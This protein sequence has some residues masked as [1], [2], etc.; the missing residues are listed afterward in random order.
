MKNL[1]EYGWCRENAEGRSH[2]VGLKTPNAWGFHDMHGS[3]D[4]YCLDDWHPNYDGAPTDGR[5]WTEGG[6]QTHLVLRGGSWYDQPQHCRSPH[7][8]Y[9]PL[10]VPSEDHGFRVVMEVEDGAAS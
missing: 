9:Y 4:E 5:A 3:I 10:G 6:L 7:R 1:T 8:N 2:P